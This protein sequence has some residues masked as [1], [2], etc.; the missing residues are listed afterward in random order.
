MKS[1]RKYHGRYGRLVVDFE[2]HEIIED[3]LN[4]KRIW[5]DAGESYYHQ[6]II[7]SE[8][9][10]ALDPQ[11]FAIPR[12]VNEFWAG[13]PT[14]FGFRCYLDDGWI[15]LVDAEESVFYKDEYK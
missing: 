11:D 12:R 15:L 7:Y 13:G 2:N 4:R 8:I 9:I 5:K 10:D 1:I 14:D 6:S 3:S